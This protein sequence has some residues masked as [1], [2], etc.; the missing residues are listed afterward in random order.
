MNVPDRKQV[1]LFN[2][3]G[4]S[5]LCFQI[6]NLSRQAEANMGNHLSILHNI[7]PNNQLSLIFHTEI[8]E[9]LNWVLH[10]QI[11]KVFYMP[12]VIIWPFLSL[13]YSAKK[14]QYQIWCI[15]AYLWVYKFSCL[16]R[17]KKFFKAEY[18]RAKM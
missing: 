9:Y 16:K 1:N 18:Y 17:S 5:H 11:L 3:I 15:S 8:V 2:W 10:S 6:D 7:P 14:N 13:H 4:S 12:M